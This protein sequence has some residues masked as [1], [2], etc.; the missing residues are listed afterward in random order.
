MKNVITL[1]NDF[2]QGQH[3]EEMRQGFFGREARGLTS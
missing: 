2:C 1:W 3:L